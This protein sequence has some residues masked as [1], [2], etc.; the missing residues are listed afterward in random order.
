ML[1]MTDTH[2]KDSGY[3]YVVGTPIGHLDDLS[4]RAVDVL[5]SCDLILCE[6]TRHSKRL[7]QNYDIETPLRSLHA[8][9]EHQVSG[10]LIERIKAGDNMALVSDAGTPLISDP[11]FPLITEAHQQSI[12]VIP[13]PG[14]SAVI[15][16]L[17]VAGLKVQPFTFH[18]FIPPKKNQRLDFFKSISPL[19]QT[20]VFYESSHRI[21]QSMSDLTTVLTDQDLVCVG[22]ELTKRFEQLYRG[23]AEQ[24]LDM[25][26]EASNHQKGE[27]VVAISGS[28][29]T[30]IDT[31][32]ASSQQLAILLKPLLPP[33]Q[34]A[35]VVADHYH[36]NK[37][38]VYEFIINLE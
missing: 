24:V 21:I 30:Q 17:S 23:S 13:I 22:R 19:N 37:K 15:S 29:V 6:D 32:E 18:G 11:G 25:L 3:L 27:F 5:K 4:F 20:H 33:K 35:A 7:F 38:Q 12:R 28:A 10:A 14:P 34:A 36:V 31:L 26:M 8:H 2:R 16:L 9:N 1:I